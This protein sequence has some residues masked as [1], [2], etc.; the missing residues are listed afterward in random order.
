MRNKHIEVG[1]PYIYN[2]VR[3][4]VKYHKD[5]ASFV[6]NRIVGFEVRAT[7]YHQCTNAG[8]ASKPT[9]HHHCTVTSPCL[10]VCPF[11]LKVEPFSVNHKYEDW[12]QLSTCSP[13]RMVQSG[14][15]PQRVDQAGEVVWT[16][17]VKWDFSDVKWASRWDLYLLVTDDQI[18]WFSIINSLMIVIFLS[19]MVAMIMMRTLNHDIATYNEAMDEEDGR[20]ETG[21]KLVHGDVFRPPA[22][23][24]ILSVCVGTGAQLIACSFILLI[25]TCLGFLSPANRG[26]LLTAMLLL[27]VFMGIFAG[28]FGSR[29]YKMFKGVDWKTNTVLTAMAFPSIVFG[30]FFVLNFFVWGEHSSGGYRTISSIALAPSAASL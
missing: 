8:R 3:L 28:Y 1:V 24:N 14:M 9:L 26:G 27:F 16:Y 11:F 29:T 5:K 13:L 15:V 18:H 2:H 7:L 6:G 23:F 25:C 30:V 12:P 19:G 20:E 10:C 21:W 22:Y 17:D 4:I